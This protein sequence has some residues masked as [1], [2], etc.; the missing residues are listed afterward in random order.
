[1][2]KTTKRLHANAIRSVKREIT[3]IGS[4]GIIMMALLKAGFFV[5]IAS[6]KANLMRQR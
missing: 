3:V 4:P 1:M 5:S 2:V 6:S